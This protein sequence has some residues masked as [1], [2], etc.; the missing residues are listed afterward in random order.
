MK[1]AH[2]TFFLMLLIISSNLYA[3]G[4]L[5]IYS[6]NK[7]G[8][9]KLNI[10]N[11]LQS[12]FST[13]SASETTFQ[14][15]Y[16]V[17]APDFNISDLKSITLSVSP[18]FSVSVDFPADRSAALT[19]SGLSFQTKKSDDNSIYNYKLFIHR[20]QKAKIPYVLNFGSSFSY[21]AT[22]P[23]FKGW[24]YRVLSNAPVPQLTS[25][26]STNTFYLAFEPSLSSDSLV[27]NVYASN[28][29]LQNELV[30]SVNASPDGIEWNKLKSYSNDVPPNSA[31]LSQKRLSVPLLA[32]TQYI[33]FV[34]EKKAKGNPNININTISIKHK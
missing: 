5:Q 22:N 4:S 10:E 31:P 9:D 16:A 28:E 30:V 12:V 8:I 15:L 7:T 11:C 32:G 33:Q 19:Q 26:F 6:A 25:A 34:L 17:V 20:I 2:V 13:G 3:E 29:N 27:C 23:D 14:N 1:N 21:N 18:G 24:G